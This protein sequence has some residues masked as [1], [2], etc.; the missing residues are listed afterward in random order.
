VQSDSKIYRFPFIRPVLPP[1]AK[2]AHYLEP[3]YRTKWFSNFGPVAHQFETELSKRS[4]HPDEVITTANNCTSGIAAALV[5]RNVFG[6]VLVAAFTF[7]AT[8]PP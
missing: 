4:C 8:S 6:A 7:P 1:V 2:W 5:A 3:A